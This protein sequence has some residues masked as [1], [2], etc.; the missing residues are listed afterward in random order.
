MSVELSVGNLLALDAKEVPKQVLAAFVQQLRAS[1]SVRGT[2]FPSATPPASAPTDPTWSDHLATAL[3][4]SSIASSSL[5]GFSGTVRAD[6]AAAWW[7]SELAGQ[8]ALHASNTLYDWAFPAYCAGDGRTFQEYLGGDRGSWAQK[9]AD[10][11]TS[12]SYINMMINKVIAVD[13]DWLAKLNVV[14]YKL[15]RLDPAQ[16]KRAVD[17][18]AKA[19]PQAVEQWQAYNH[20]A[21]SLFQTS[22]FLGEVNSAIGVGRDGRKCHLVYA[23]REV[24]EVCDYWTDYGLGVVAFVNGPARQMGLTTGQQ[25]DNRVDKSPK[26]GVTGAAPLHLATGRTTPVQNLRCGDQL[27]ARDGRPAEQP[28]GVIDV[29]GAPDTLIYGFNDLEPFFTAGHL[30]WTDAGWKAL[31]PGTAG[32]EGPHPGVGELAVGDVLHRIR[33]GRPVSYEPVQIERFTSRP[34]RPDERL[35][36]MQLSGPTSYHV[37]GHLAKAVSPRWTERRLH[38]ALG[39]LSPAERR[40]L[41]ALIEPAMPLIRKSVGGCVEEAI[42]RALAQG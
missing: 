7:Q 41:G 37:H 38:A 4:C 36:G 3:I 18:W 16:E 32:R 42:R 8:T 21:P 24:I 2:F 11:V 27:L 39:T 13:P 25:P 5:Y 6:G 1:P 35:Y 33:E 31:R 19:Y 20:V 12:D 14:Y 30:F 17:V 23:A 26:D 34:L 9:L 15:H 40:H 28:D 10:R 29:T 22:T